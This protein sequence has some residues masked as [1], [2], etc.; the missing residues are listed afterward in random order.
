MAAGA[1]T[2]VG[3]ALGIMFVTLQQ[4]LV[5]LKH[6]MCYIIGNIQEQ[7]IIKGWAHHNEIMV[8]AVVVAVNRHSGG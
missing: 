6:N 3:E 4:T 8:R 5:F 1:K 2:T 7:Y